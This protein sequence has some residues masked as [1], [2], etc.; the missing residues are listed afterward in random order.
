MKKVEKASEEDDP[1]VIVYEKSKTSKKNK[2]KRTRNKNKAD[3]KEEELVFGIKDDVQSIEEEIEIQ[4]GS[5]TSIC[6]QCL[7]VVSSSAKSILR[8]F[9]VVKQ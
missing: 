2:K 3:S 8:Y 4:G 1:E 7:D 5:A 9:G 6:A